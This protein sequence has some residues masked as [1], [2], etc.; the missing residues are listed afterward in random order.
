[1]TLRSYGALVLNQSYDRRAGIIG[2]YDYTKVGAIW[3]MGESYQIASDG[4]S[5]GNLY[6]AAYKYSDFGNAGGHQF[7]WCGNGEVT[8]ALGEN[9]WVRNN[10][11][12][13]GNVGIG[14]TSPA[15]KLDVAGNIR[16]TGNLSANGLEIPTSAPANPVSGKWYLYLS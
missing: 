16:A 6:G 13:Q 1:M 11:I 9:F 2:T 12:I 4:S 15:N 3:S 8:V 10:A 7:C 14:T 5:F